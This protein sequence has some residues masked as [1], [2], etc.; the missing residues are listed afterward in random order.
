[1]EIFLYVMLALAVVMASLLLRQLRPELAIILVIAA[2]VAIM[3]GL[4]GK[5]AT[6]IRMVEELAKRANVGTM[7][8]NTLIKIM[9][10]AYVAEYGA[11]ICKD[12]GENSL[13]SKVELAGKLTILSLSVPV[14]LVILETLLSIIP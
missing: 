2:S 1:M 3:I 9:G 10:V 11:Q 7:H 8:M 4:L 5:M 6:V 13:A 14:V 12:A